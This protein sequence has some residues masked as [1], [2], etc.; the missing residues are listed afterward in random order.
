MVCNVL[1]LESDSVDRARWKT[2]HNG[3][4]TLGLVLQLSS[5]G[6][7]GVIHILSQTTDKD[8]RLKLPVLICGASTG[9]IVLSHP[10]RTLWSVESQSECVGAD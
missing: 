6:L 5:D 7:L 1:P 8:E 4:K 10:R 9:I 2:Q 3:T